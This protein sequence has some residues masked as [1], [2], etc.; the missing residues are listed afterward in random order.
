M[1]LVPFLATLESVVYSD[2]EKE[3]NLIL[4]NSREGGKEERM[5]TV[6]GG[7]RRVA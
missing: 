1:V 6:L 4:R 7:N 3:R 5:T 2:G